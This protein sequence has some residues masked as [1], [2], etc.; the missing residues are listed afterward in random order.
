M[1]RSL[2]SSIILALV[3][4]FATIT[5]QAQNEAVQRGN[6]AIGS[7]IGYTNTV[8]NI[9]INTGGAVTQGGN[10]AFQL[11]LTPSIGYFV[12]NNWVV[13]LGMDYLVS[14]SQNNNRE[15]AS[16]ADRTADTKLLFG[17]YSRIYFPFAG[18]QALFIGAVYGYGRSETEITTDGQAQLVNTTLMT[19]GA[20]PGYTI[21]SNRKVS[22]EAQAKYNYGAS[23]NVF[24]LDGTSQT[25]RTE[26]TAWDFVLGMHFYFNR[27]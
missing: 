25:T 23:R 14:S 20:G 1:K 9:Q 10:S 22:L 2:Q 3:F 21:F 7:G 19:F 4:V 17:P 11:H 15:A 5:L 16:V 12:A 8:T 24:Q 13:G 27:Q 18:D 26:T 6:F